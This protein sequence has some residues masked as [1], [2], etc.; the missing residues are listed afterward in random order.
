MIYSRPPYLQWSSKIHQRLYPSINL[1]DILPDTPS[2]VSVKSKLTEITDGAVGFDGDGG[3]LF[4]SEDADMALGTGDFT[5]EAFIYNNVHRNY[6]NYIGTRESGQSDVG[7][8]GVLLQTQMLIYIG[9]LMAC[10]I[11]LFF[12]ANSWYHIACTKLV[13]LINGLLMEFRKTN[14]TIRYYTDD[15]L[16]IGDNSYSNAT[17]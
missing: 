11:L 5:V 4:V 8:S 1:P 16:T 6:V 2:G 14:T 9:I 10:M 7:Y 12:G 15:L 3:Q 17:Q 13:V